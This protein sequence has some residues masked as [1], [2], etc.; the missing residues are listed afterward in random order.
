MQDCI[1]AVDNFHSAGE[2]ILYFKLL[3]KCTGD[4]NT[5]MLE[6]GR[7]FTRAAEYMPK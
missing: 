5:I 3:Q 7:Q 4:V 1:D 2:I 6:V